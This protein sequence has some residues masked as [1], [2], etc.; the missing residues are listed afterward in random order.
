MVEHEFTEIALFGDPQRHRSGLVSNHPK[1]LGS[2][3]ENNSWRA[4]SSINETELAM[5]SSL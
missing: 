5:A 3:V 4:C 1:L 2:E